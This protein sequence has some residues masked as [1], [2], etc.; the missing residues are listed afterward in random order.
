MKYEK[1][2][3]VLHKLIKGES[4]LTYPHHK[5]L[6]FGNYTTEITGTPCDHLFWEWG[7]DI[8]TGGPK[9]ASPYPTHVCLDFKFPEPPN[10]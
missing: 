9:I 3:M 10:D 6:P 4:Y 8:N 2:E 7:G 5:I 1:I